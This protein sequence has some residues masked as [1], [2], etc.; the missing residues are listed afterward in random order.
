LTVAGPLDIQ[1]YPRGLID[2]FG[3]KAT[4]DTPH[5]LSDQISGE[6]DLTDL[7]L[8]ARCQQ[9]NNVTAVVLAA[10]GNFAFI[11]SGPAANE[12]WLVYGVTVDSQ[13]TAAATAIKYS[14]VAF[15]VA[16]SSGPDFVAGEFSLG[17]SDRRLDGKNWERPMVMRPGDNF[18]LVV[19]TITGAPGIQPRLW[20]Y[21]ASLLI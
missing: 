7:Y 15:R 9:I 11:N 2:L 10:T 12:I 1:R 17:A 13:P 3:M 16:A 20:V 19:S 14:L 6:L 4:G 8:N 18:G 5:T 21:Y